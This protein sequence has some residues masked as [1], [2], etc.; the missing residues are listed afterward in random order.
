MTGAEQSI[1]ERVFQYGLPTALLV[2]FVVGAYRVLKPMADQALSRLLKLVD[3]TSEVMRENADTLRV[4]KG[5]LEQIE[6]R[7][8]KIDPPKRPRNGT[9]AP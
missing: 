3:D 8:E 9:S 5:S 4:I 2:G 1:I 6:R 7:L